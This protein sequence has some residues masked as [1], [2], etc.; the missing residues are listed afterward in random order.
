MLYTESASA[1]EEWS[2]WATTAATT[3]STTGT[4]TTAATTTATT[5]LVVTQ[6]RIEEMRNNNIEIGCNYSL[7][8]PSVSPIIAQRP[9]R[10]RL[11]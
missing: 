5:R 8:S 9:E 2:G 11:Y 4:A 7:L 1:L 10:N 3:T 6:I